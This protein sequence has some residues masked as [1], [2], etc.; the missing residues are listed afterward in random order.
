MRNQSLILLSK[1]FNVHFYELIT[2]LL[3]K[4]SCLDVRVPD[5]L[6]IDSLNKSSANIFTYALN[7]VPGSV[8]QIW[9]IKIETLHQ[10]LSEHKP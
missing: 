2:N 1:L 4:L 8:D 10:S 7:F 5:F 6:N 3:T 9:K